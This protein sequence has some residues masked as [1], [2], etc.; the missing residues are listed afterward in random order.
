MIASVGAR[1]DYRG[2]HCSADGGGIVL[3]G[4]GSSFEP[5]TTR[6]PM[7]SSAWNVSPRPARANQ[8]TELPSC[9]SVFL[10]PEGDFAGRLIEASRAEG[11]ARSATLEVSTETREL[12]REPRQ[13]PPRP[14]CS[15]WSSGPSAKWNE[16]F[17][18]K[19]T[20]EFELW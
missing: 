19:L 14:T 4:D 1:F 15:R 10:K 5:E 13:R 3:A 7:S 6:T 2:S 9:G 16:R 8:P 17:D 12:L 18:V 11:A 20:R